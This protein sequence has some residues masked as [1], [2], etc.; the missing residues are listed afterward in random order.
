MSS[1]VSRN[2]QHCFSVLGVF[3]GLLANVNKVAW[4]VHEYDFDIVIVQLFLVK[5]RYAHLPMFNSDEVDFMIEILCS[6]LSGLSVSA[7]MY[8]LMC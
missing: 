7:L 1:P 3:L 8:V 4:S 5:H 6:L 2:A